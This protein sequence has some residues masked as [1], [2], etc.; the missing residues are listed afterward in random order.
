MFF[1]FNKLIFGQCCSAGNPVGGDGSN[2]GLNKK[3]LRVSVMYKYSLSQVYFHNESQVD[4]PFTDK[5]YFDYN[6]LSITYGLLNRLSLHSEIGYFIDKTQKLNMNNENI[7]INSNG[8]GD[9]LFNARYTLIKTVKPI[10]QLVLSAGARFPIGAFNEEING[11]AIPMSLQPSSGALK[12]NTSAFYSRKRIENKIGFTIFTLFENSRTI[13]QDYLVYKYGN[14]FQFSLAGSYSI[15]KNFIF[16]A[17]A[18]FELRAKDE[19]EFGLK[20]E[21]TGSRVVY[22][23]P[24]ILYSIKTKWNIIF[25][26]DIPIYKYVNGYQLTNKF[27]FQIGLSRNISFRYQK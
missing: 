14:Y 2:V 18:K 9:L 15:S 20:I 25:M 23:N 3:A 17:N 27:S 21:S 13:N 4:V 26:T 12:Y 19:R 7:V 6:N 24:Q 16:I 11:V 10:S 1:I 5:S 22:F 8:L